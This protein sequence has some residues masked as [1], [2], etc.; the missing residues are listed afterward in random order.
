MRHLIVGLLLVA[1]LSAAAHAAPVCPVG[2]TITTDTAG[3]CCWPGQAWSKSRAACVGIPECP[4]GTQAQGESCVAAACAPGQAVTADTHGHCCWPAQVWSEQRGVCVGIPQCPSGTIANGEQCVVTQS[5]V[6][7][8]PSAYYSTSQN[9]Y[10][11]PQSAYYPPPQNAYAPPNAYA[12]PSNVP[13]DPSLRVPVEFLPA[14]KENKY[15]IVIQ[16]TGCTAPCTLML[17]PGA[18]ELRTT[19]AGQITE[20]LTVPAVPSTVKMQ[21][22]T[23]KEVIGGAVM[24]PVGITLFSTGAWMLSTYIHYSPALAGTGGALLG[25]GGGLA[26]GGIL[27]LLNIRGKHVDVVPKGYARS[28]LRLVD[29]GF[30]KVRNDGFAGGA[31]FSF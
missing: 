8:P 18:T 28:G 19:G 2:Q 9:A 22:F 7:A 11:P 25:V 5:P 23:L 14:N 26:I 13:V 17:A 21:H 31:R 24:T 16:G 3:H 10:P 20:F 29:I 6:N 12:T 30:G 27:A 4:M 15:N 1:A